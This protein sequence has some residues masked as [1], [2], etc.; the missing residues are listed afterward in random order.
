MAGQN[1][2]TG[3]NLSEEGLPPNLADNCSI[4]FHYAYLKLQRVRANKHLPTAAD[5][6]A[7]PVFVNVHV[8][9]VSCPATDMCICE[10]VQAICEFCPGHQ[11]EAVIN[12]A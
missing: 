1:V 10:L 12:A 3:M 11:N 5:Q 4:P 6:Y 2:S 8:M 9:P 7:T